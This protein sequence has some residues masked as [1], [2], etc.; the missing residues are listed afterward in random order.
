V[1]AGV[2]KR[3]AVA[4]LAAAIAAVAGV[5]A[6]GGPAEASTAAP[7]QTPGTGE[8]KLVGNFIREGDG[9]ANSVANIAEEMFVYVPGIAADTLVDFDRPGGP[10][11]DVT[12]DETIIPVNGSY[13]PVAGNFDADDWDEIL[14]YGPGTAPDFM[15]NFDQ[16]NLPPV[17]TP[18]QVNGTYTPLVGDFTDDGVEDVFWYA[19]GTA[20]DHIWEFDENGSYRTQTYT[21][22]GTYTPLVGSFADD[23]TDD[24]LWYAPGTAADYLW[25]F[26]PGQLT[27]S[28]RTYQANGTY[29]PF[30]LNMFGDGDGGDDVFWY[31]PGTA[32]D[33]IWDFN[34][35]I[36]SDIPQT[37][38]GTFTTA[39]G[40]FFGDDHDDI[41]FF[42]S[43]GFVLW[44]HTENG[45]GVTRY[46]YLFFDSMSGLS[47]SAAGPS[48]SR[49][50]TEAPNGAAGTSRGTINR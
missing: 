1:E 16:G 32:P 14:W 40:D 49:A 47:A 12:Y 20:Q 28:S 33:Y 50:M 27:Y 6:V 31:A 36:R 21:A 38:N 30:V 9:G 39:A 11:T 43:A 25:D 35:G 24:I 10:G 5:G 22:N 18:L 29:K 19:P 2:N 37:V 26:N 17:S 8:V 34:L 42:N 44:E 4:G 46:E 23:G 7:A 45:S 13:R 48:A 15:W 41:L 3:K